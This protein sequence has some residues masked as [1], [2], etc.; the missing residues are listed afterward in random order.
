MW[1]SSNG[2]RARDEGAPRPPPEE[3]GGMPVTTFATLGQHCQP[4]VV[5]SE[6]ART[7]SDREN[8]RAVSHHR[9]CLEMRRSQSKSRRFLES[10][11]KCLYPC[12]QGDFQGRVPRPRRR[13]Q[14]RWFAVHAVYSGLISC[15]VRVRRNLSC[16]QYGA[17][18]VWSGMLFWRAGTATALPQVREGEGWRRPHWVQGRAGM[19]RLA[20][21]QGIGATLWLS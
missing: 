12:P 14:R 6:Q 21:D 3:V 13:A 9:R 2:G 4:A 20:R 7:R 19:P 16:V 1:C 10:N 17:K 5:T 18:P 15:S 11:A 8:R